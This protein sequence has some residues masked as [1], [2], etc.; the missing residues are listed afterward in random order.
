M[1]SR[2]YASLLLTFRQGIDAAPVSVRPRI[3]GRPERGALR[4][5]GGSTGKRRT[6]Y[7][8]AIVVLKHHKN[9]GHGVRGFR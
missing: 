2:D 4:V 5:A 3:G 8:S 7:A 1:T 9:Q 6:G